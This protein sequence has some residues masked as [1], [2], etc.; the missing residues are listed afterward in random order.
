MTRVDGPDHRLMLLCRVIAKEHGVTSDDGLG[1][2]QA[3][4]C[5]LFL[6]CLALLRRKMGSVA[7]VYD[8]STLEADP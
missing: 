2:R 7:H 4:L 6:C 8:P 5:S 1:C 3:A